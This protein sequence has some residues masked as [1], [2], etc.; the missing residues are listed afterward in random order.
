[1]DIQKTI[2]RVFR[3]GIRSKLGNDITELLSKARIEIKSEY[4]SKE[5]LIT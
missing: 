5:H 2:T 1:M 3:K 4:S